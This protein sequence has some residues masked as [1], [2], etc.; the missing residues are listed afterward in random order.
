MSEYKPSLPII[1]ISMLLLDDMKRIK[2]PG[3]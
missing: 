1:G 2:N 3:Q